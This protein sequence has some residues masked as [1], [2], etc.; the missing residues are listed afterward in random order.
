MKMNGSKSDLNG[1]AVKSVV[2]C[3]PAR[4]DFSGER[5]LY[6]RGLEYLW[7]ATAIF[8]IKLKTKQKRQL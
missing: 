1:L 3:F 5:F 8:G 2:R 4:V 7:L 6:I